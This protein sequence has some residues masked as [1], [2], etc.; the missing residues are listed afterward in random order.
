MI[1]LCVSIGLSGTWL[2]LAGMKDLKRSASKQPAM[3]RPD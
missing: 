3:S 1:R 2:V